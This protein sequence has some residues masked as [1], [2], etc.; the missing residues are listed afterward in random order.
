MCTPCSIGPRAHTT[1][2]KRHL[3]RLTQFKAHCPRT[4]AG[5]SFPQKLP[6]RLP[7]SRHSS[8]T[9]DEV[10]SHIC[11]RNTITILLCLRWSRF[12]AVF[13]CKSSAVAEMGHRLATICMARKWAVLLLGAGSPF[14]TMRPGLGSTSLPSHIWIH[15]TVL[16]QLY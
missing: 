16:S 6:L 3:D 2:P 1:Q 10:T 12:I 14:N 15:P 9:Y 4:C 5:M 7:Q 11:G 8:S 13:E